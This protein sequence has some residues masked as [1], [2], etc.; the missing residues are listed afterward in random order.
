M[1]KK[2]NCAYG[3][4]LPLKAGIYFMGMAISCC[5]TAIFTLNGLGSDAMNTLFTAIAS[6]MNILPGRIYTVFNLTMLLAGF[7]LARRYMGIGSVLMILVQG[8]FIDIWMSCFLSVPW[9]FEGAGWKAAMAALGYVC[10]T[11]GCALST[12]MCLGTA[13]FEACLFTLADRIRVEYKYLK[14]FSEIF[15]FAAALAL[16]G[17]YGV[18]TII[19]V[20]FYGCGLSFFMVGLNKTVWRRWDIDDRRNDLSRNNRRKTFAGDAGEE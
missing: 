14:M 19:E 13:G 11:F 1:E 12:S 9:L 20:L 6:R 10:R 15:Y 17:V 8:F 3:K 4:K 16:G 2:Q 7:L 5:G 18:M